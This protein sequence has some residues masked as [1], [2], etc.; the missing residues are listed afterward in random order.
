[1][2]ALQWTCELRTKENHDVFLF[3][4]ISYTRKVLLATS[5]ATHVCVCVC[6]CVLVEV[7]VCVAV[8]VLVMV[9]EDVI[10]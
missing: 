4:D 5:N 2:F 1:M 7:C 9:A 8:I 10:V 6:V 3:R